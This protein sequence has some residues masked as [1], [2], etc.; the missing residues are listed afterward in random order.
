MGT[1]KGDPQTNHQEKDNHPEGTKLG[2]YI[3]GKYSW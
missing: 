1:G 3:L 2:H